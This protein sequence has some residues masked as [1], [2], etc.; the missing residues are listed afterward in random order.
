MYIGGGKINTIDRIKDLKE[1]D[2]GRDVIY[3]IESSYIDAR[4]LGFDNYNVIITAFFQ[5]PEIIRVEREDL[6]W[7]KTKKKPDYCYD[8]DQDMDSCFRF[9]PYCGDELG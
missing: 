9:C 4:I 8:C 1:S 2:I 7:G 6:I 5:G 3:C